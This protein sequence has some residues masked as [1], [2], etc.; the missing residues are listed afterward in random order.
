MASP[1]DFHDEL[2]ETLN[3][4]RIEWKISNFFSLTEEQGYF[5]Q[6]SVFSFAGSSWNLMI[7]PG[8]DYTIQDEP[9]DYI[10]V[11]LE[12]NSLV[13]PP[14]TLTYTFGVKKANGTLKNIVEKKRSFTQNFAASGHQKFL[15]R[16]ELLRHQRELVPSG[17]LIITCT[18]KQD[19][20]KIL[21]NT[22]PRM[23]LAGK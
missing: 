3:V 8:G 6:S 23:K 4:L 11:Y 15:R 16:S 2:Q 12:A 13:E 5:Y 9:T 14:V 19:G 22:F 7:F 18:M 17:D 20:V 1:E 10:S 21:D